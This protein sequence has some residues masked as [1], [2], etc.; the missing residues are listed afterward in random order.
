[1]QDRLQPSLLDRLTDDDPTNKKESREQRFFSLSRLRAAVLRD[2]SWLLNTAQFGAT[3]DLSAYP[4][5]TVSVLNYGVP[6]FSGKAIEGLRSNEVQ[7]RMTSALRQFEP[8]LL[9]ETVSV[10]VAGTTRSTNTIEFRIEGDLWA[11]PVPVRMFMK[12]EMDRELDT[13]RV[14]EHQ[15]SRRG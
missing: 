10:T 9:A 6:V 1:M 12:T 2:L 8:R 11:Q 15:G 4:H 13:I 7:N 3:D 5:V 14:V